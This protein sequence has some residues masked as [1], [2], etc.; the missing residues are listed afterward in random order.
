MKN[1]RI[2]GLLFFFFITTPAYAQPSSIGQQVER[3]V[4]QQTLTPHGVITLS[5]QANEQLYK[6]LTAFFKPSTAPFRLLRHRLP[7]SNIPTTFRV[8]HAGEPTVTASAFAVEVNGRIFGVTAGHVMKNI[9]DMEGRRALEERKA[10]GIYGDS[11]Y[12]LPQMRV[13]TPDG[14]FISYDISSWRLSNPKG[15]DVAVF[16]IP[17]QMR[18]YVQPLPIATQRA[19]PRQIASIAGFAYDKPLWFRAE[20]ILFS[21]PHRML[22]RKSSTGKIDGMCGSPVL[23]DGKVTGLYVGAYLKGETQLFL[24]NMPREFYSKKFPDMHYAAPIENIF[25]LINDLTGTRELPTITMQVFGRPVAQLRPEDQLYS[26]KLFRNNKMEQLTH[27]DQL[28][29]PEHLENLFELQ[30]N[31]ILRITVMPHTYTPKKDEVIEYDINVSSGEVVRHIL[32]EESSPS[33]PPVK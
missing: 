6:Q 30:E 9:A 5:R 8:H 11:D 18:A 23:V 29:D 26:I 13:R 16:E 12:F 7:P 32:Q 31:D 22:L 4:L 17:A 19:Q 21:T 20:E 3:A 24:W 2:F 25:P 1:F 14:S 15:S 10:Q 28:T 27:A 33:L